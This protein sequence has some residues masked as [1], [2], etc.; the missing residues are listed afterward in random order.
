M[1]M[2]LATRRWTVAERDRLPRDG[3]RYEVVRGELF[4]TPMPSP[5]HQ[6]TVKRLFLPINAFVVQHSLGSAYDSGTDVHFSDEDVVVPDLVVYPFGPD[7]LPD[8]WLAAPKPLLV[9]EVRSQTTWR[10]DVGPKRRL[11]M[12]GAVPE[13][14]I[15][16]GDAREVRIVRPGRADEIARDVIRWQPAGTEI[17]LEIDLGE[18]FR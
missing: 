1:F 2:D 4:V 16:N 9:V 14:W 5:R 10:R 15:V 6:E 17:A 13:Y 3:N 7:E 8:K 12:E 11:Y 18:V